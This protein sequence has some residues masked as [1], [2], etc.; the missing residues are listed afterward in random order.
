MPPALA[1][2]S[3]SVSIPALLAA[4]ANSAVAA[5]YHALV[6]A[7]DRAVAEGDG[8][9]ALRQS[10]LDDYQ[11][12]RGRLRSLQADAARVGTVADAPRAMP[13]FE[14]VSAFSPTVVPR[15]NEGSIAAAAAEVERARVALDSMDASIAVTS[16][17]TGRLRDVVESCDA[18]LGGSPVDMVLPLVTP[19]A[20]DEAP[21]KA[22]ANAA[23]MIEALKAERKDVERA[24]LPA[25]MVRER[26]RQ[27]IENLAATGLPKVGG[28]A[29]GRHISWPRT[30]G[31]EVDTLAV[32][33]AG[34]PELLI[35]IAEAQIDAEFDST[36]TLAMSPTEQA[37]R[38]DEIAGK[39]LLQERIAATAAWAIHEDGGHL[40]FLPGLDARAVLGIE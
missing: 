30:H 32:L 34:M 36:E 29:R 28:L 15:V 26:A 18:F 10:R 9:H 25:A 39:M 20:I 37:R 35:E 23:L 24:V 6:D 40:D 8:L 13:V 22:I 27:E 7:R 2:R 14:G 5:K 11:T 4:P 19:I 16:R 33:A 17:R 31:G 1:A 12:A 38:L 21:A 3:A